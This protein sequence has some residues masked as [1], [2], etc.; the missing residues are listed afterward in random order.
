MKVL[1][2][3]CQTPSTFGFI[4]IDLFGF[5]LCLTNQGL[6][7]LIVSIGRQQSAKT[8][9]MMMIG[10]I[11]SPPHGAYLRDQHIPDQKTLKESI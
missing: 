2:T 8:T 5:L 7:M 6:M 4:L 9:Q 3:I 11:K 1:K 10:K